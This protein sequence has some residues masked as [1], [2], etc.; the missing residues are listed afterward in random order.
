MQ[1]STS[2]CLLISRSRAA[3]LLYLDVRQPIRDLRSKSGCRAKCQGAGE[4]GR[5]RAG[6]SGQTVSRTDL[7]I[8]K[9]AMGHRAILHAPLS[10]GD[11]DDHTVADAVSLRLEATIEAIVTDDLP[12]MEA[13]LAAEFNRSDR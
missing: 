3:G 8:S 5:Q 9:D 12:E 7:E 11:F 1:G 10:R 13:A 4:H 6:G 2:T